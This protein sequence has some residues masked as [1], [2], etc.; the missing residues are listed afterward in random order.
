[1]NRTRSLQRAIKDIISGCKLWLQFFKPQKKRT[2]I[3]KG[4]FA[5][6]GIPVHFE[7][8]PFIYFFFRVNLGKITHGKHFEG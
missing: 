5:F 6:K 1:M 7:P 3:I 4:F 2:K 8:D